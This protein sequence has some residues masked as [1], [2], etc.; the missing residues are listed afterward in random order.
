MHDT[1]YE[2]G[3]LFFAIYGR[4]GQMIV[5]LGSYNVNGTLRDFSP[6]GAVYLGLDLEAGPGVDICVQGQP[7]PLRTDFADLVVSS[8]AFEHDPF[9][10]ETFVELTRILRPGG[11]LYLNVPSNGVFH[12]YPQEDC[13]RF[14]PD[15]GRAF[16]RLAQKNGYALTLVESFL[17]ERKRGF[18]NDFVAVF[19]KAPS[20]D[21]G[22]VRFISDH[23]ACTNAIRFGEPNILAERKSPEDMVIIKT[24][25]GEVAQ[26]KRVA[27][28][29]NS[30]ATP[31]GDTALERLQI[32]RA[33]TARLRQSLEQKTLDRKTKS[34]ADC[35]RNS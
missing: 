32:L 35:D 34:I 27:R 22:A 26:L 7:L 10:W 11:F 6:N 14:Y 5:E 4:P 21:L 25:R 15:C 24:L 30:A 1:A 29:Q 31:N 9:F 12:R 23:V 13:W 20:V 3:K 17:A 18:W 8:S 19:V 2:I 16:E 28:D 33:H